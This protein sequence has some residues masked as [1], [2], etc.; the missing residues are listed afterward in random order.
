MNYFRAQI[1]RAA[2]PLIR[3]PSDGECRSDSGNF[4]EA[5]TIP[6]ENSAP[7][8]NATQPLGREQQLEE[9]LVRLDEAWGRLFRRITTDIKESDYGLPPAQAFVLY[10]L[11]NCGAQR[12]SDL[13]A[14]L[15]VTQSACTALVDRIIQ[16]GLVHRRRDDGDRRVVWV[17]ITE[18]GSQTLDRLRRVRAKLLANYFSRLDPDEI[19]MLATL[20]GRAVDAVSPE[21]IPTQPPAH[22]PAVSLTAIAE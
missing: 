19:G 17:E 4:K 2:T 6:V 20:I 9:A 15:D 3:T 11:E 13:A 5:E 14:H 10:V 21:L 1:D 18:A 7:V 12:M 8:D 22:S 16:A